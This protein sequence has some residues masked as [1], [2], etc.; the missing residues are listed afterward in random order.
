ML[1]VFDYCVTNLVDENDLVY[2]NVVKLG[3]RFVV[4]DADA[5]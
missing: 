1:L 4:I 5:Y 2:V 3:L